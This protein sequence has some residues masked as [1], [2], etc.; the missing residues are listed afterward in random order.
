[1]GIR[2]N[3]KRRAKVAKQKKQ[4]QVRIEKYNAKHGIEGENHFTMTPMPPSTWRYD[5]INNK[6][7]HPE[8]RRR[9]LSAP[10]IG[11]PLP[12]DQKDIFRCNDLANRLRRA[13]LEAP[14]Y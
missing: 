7:I 13:E 1:M 11:E 2:E 8:D 5:T 10:L 9:M 3:E 14:H 4:E 6:W 12:V